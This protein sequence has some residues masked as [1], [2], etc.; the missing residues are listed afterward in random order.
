MMFRVRNNILYLE[1]Y[2]GKSIHVGK[3]WEIQ[4]R[5]IVGSYDKEINSQAQLLY[6]ARVELQMINL[7]TKCQTNWGKEICS[8]GDEPRRKMSLSFFRT[9]GKRKLSI[10]DLS[11]GNAC[12][13]WVVSGGFVTGQ[14]KAS[15]NKDYQK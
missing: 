8:Q 10:R 2:S 15:L 9:N 12:Q 1:G 6:I 4:L 3:E 7:A 5:S 14:K 13:A 11:E